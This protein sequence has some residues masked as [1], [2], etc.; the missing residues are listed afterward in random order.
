MIPWG[1]SV[2]VDWKPGTAHEHRLRL[3]VPLFLLWLILLPLLL[4]LFPLIA[5]GCLYFRVNAVNL[6][7][8]AWGIVTSLRRTW[9][10][11]KTGEFWVRV[12]LA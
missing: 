4:V 3:W 12:N 10:E 8:T 5:L 6:Y 7:G 1:A 9:V 2:Q 11:V